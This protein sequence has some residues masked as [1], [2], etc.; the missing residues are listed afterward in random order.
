M[1]HP[2]KGDGLIHP[3]RKARLDA[4]LSARELA[5]RV[6]VSRQLI[7]ALEEGVRRGSLETWLKISQELNVPVDELVGGQEKAKAG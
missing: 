3:L 6:G 5:T 4:D 7:Y 1:S 2:T